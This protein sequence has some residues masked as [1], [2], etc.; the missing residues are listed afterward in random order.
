M[1][2][3]LTMGLAD[4][5]LKVKENIALSAAKSG[6]SADDITLVAV[7][8]TVGAEKMVELFGLGHRIF[9]ESRIGETLEKKQFL[10]AGME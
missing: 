9:G 7:S 8:K 5:Y 4:N 6:R 10:P 1:H 3:N 2:Y